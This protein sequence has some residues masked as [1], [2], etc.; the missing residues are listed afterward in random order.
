MNGPRWRGWLVAAGIMLLGITLGAAG[1]AWAGTRIFREALQTAGERGFADRA[2]SRIGADLTSSLN[3]T[4]DESARIQ[5]ILKQSASNL[6]QVRT[7]AAAQAFAELRATSQRIAAELPPDKR[8][9]YQKLIA[10][11]YS[12]LG[13]PPPATK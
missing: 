11:R 1:M 5:V 12:R 3:L 6:K 4:P 13:L 10:K 2:A 7:Q 9:E 8:E